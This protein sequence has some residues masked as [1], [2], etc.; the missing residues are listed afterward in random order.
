MN[1]WVMKTAHSTLSMNT[2]PD[3]DGFDVYAICH[4]L[5]RK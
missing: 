5:S 1:Y 2:F 3:T 4:D